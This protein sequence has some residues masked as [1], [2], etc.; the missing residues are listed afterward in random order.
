MI[1][2]TTTIPQEIIWAANKIPF[3]LNNAFVSNNP[4]NYIN[5]AESLGIIRNTCSWIKGMLGVIDD[6]QDEIEAIIVVTQGD[7]SNNHSLIELAS[8]FFP[9]LQ[10]IKFAYPAD[11]D[12]QQLQLELNKL[13]TKL[14]TNLIHANEI[15]KILSPIRNKLKNLIAIY[16]E[17]NNIPAATMQ[18]I[19]VSSTDFNGDYQKY[20]SEIDNYFKLMINNPSNNKLIKIGVIGVPTIIPNFYSYLEEE[21]KVN[22]NLFEVEEDFCMYDSYSSLQE[23][24]L[25][26]K[27]PYDLNSRIE[28]INKA[29]YSRQ[30]KGIVH[31]V[32]TFCHRQIDDTL[33]K[34]TLNT[35]TI[36]LEADAPEKI[37]MR[38]KIRLENFIE[39]IIDANT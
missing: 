4:L 31:Y 32:Q 5:K 16:Q 26:F 23:Q 13:A 37:D 1:A 22:V 34:K 6:Y 18:K 12:S 27:Y 17:K 28:W 20:E 30:L 25:K 10:I 3:D 11:K 38:S 39:R 35:P 33:I 9:K 21:L 29:I 2:F 14:D 8:H 24:Y 36:T 7:C 15:K 19:L